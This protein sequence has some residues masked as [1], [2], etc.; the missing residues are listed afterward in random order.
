M[1]ATRFLLRWFVIAVLMALASRSTAAWGQEG[2]SA[3]ASAEKSATTSTEEK[4]KSKF[5]QLTTGLTKREG[6]WTTYSKDQQLLVDLKTSDLSKEYIV[7]TSIARGIS[8]GWV[9]GGMSWNFGDDI[10]WTFRKVGDKL[11]V[12]RRNVRFRAKDK[13][14]EASA[15]KLAYSDSVLYALPILTDTSGGHLV[16]FSR[17]F[18]SDDVEIGRQIG[19][20]FRFVSDR[21]T[22]AS[23][24]SFPENLEVQVAAVYAGP[25]GIQ[26]TNL[27]TVPDPRGVQ[28]HVH[29]SLSELPKVGANGYKPRKADDRIGYFLTVL[30]DFSDKEDD[31]QFVRY[32]N[33][34]HL[35]K[36][37]SEIAVSPPEKPIRFH[38]ER[39]VPVWLR[40]TVRAGILEWNKAYDAIGFSGAVEVLQQEDTADWDP[41]DIRYNTFRW[42]TAEAG[43]AIGPSRVDPRTGQILDAD[44]LFDAS[45]L[46][47]W[48]QEY[49]TLSA[50]T[51][52]QLRPNWSPFDGLPGR[53]A[54][55]PHGPGGHCLYCRGMQ[56]QMGFAAAVLTAQGIAKSGK[57]P[58]EF[59]HQGLKEV[60]MHEVGHT[61]GLRHNFKASSWKELKEI[62]KPDLDPAVPTVASVMDYN[63][64]NIVPSGQKQGLY[65]PQTIGPYDLWAIEYGYKSLSG[66]VDA[67]LAKIAARA[68]EPGLDYATD[69][70][71][72]MLDSDPLSNRFDLGKDPITYVRRQIEHAGELLPK[73]VDRTVEEGAGYQRARQAF[74]LLL[75]EYWR[76][77]LFAARFPGGV[78]VHRDHKGDPEARAPF[79]VVPAETQRRAM[80]LLVETTFAAP[81]FK[82]EVLNYLAS[83]R[84]SHWGIEEP[85]RVD[86]PIHETIARLQGVVLRQLFDATTLTRLQDNELKSP[87]DAETY[88]LAEHLRRIVDGVFSEWRV[89]DAKGEFTDRAPYIPGFR[90]SLQREALKQLARLVSDGN[91]DARMSDVPAPE[92]S[93]TLA[94]MHLR[95]LELQIES[96]LGRQELKMDDYSRA[97][98]MDCQALIRQVLE[99]RLEVRGVN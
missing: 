66:D 98:L 41:E 86:Y 65:F 61:L 30:K 10:I 69:E 24:K 13:S 16:D 76:S 55:P 38:I 97:H 1:F 85:D 84:W 79:V 47:F 27:E 7:L 99:A 64:A 35:V 89:T 93:R 91:A 46:Q 52:E 49:E 32:I 25:G 48:K 44:I 83:T 28:V 11:H 81:E 5:A 71:T 95:T 90:R 40:P 77:A 31:Q 88:T 22:Y 58:D 14:P 34:W 4:E 15:V 72:E 36:K 67:E 33:R 23:V 60:V 39:T 87:R 18:L 53:P 59:V 8:S 56:H 19:P 82:P 2:T 17:I 51:A 68:A 63:P 74:G 94:R 9:L 57:L 12:I 50:E 62:D 3:G 21:S 75:S 26:D 92:D 45:F 29:Y 73:V 43:F 42:I 6:M 70:D 80:E 20:G 54:P 78:H 96:L 37:D